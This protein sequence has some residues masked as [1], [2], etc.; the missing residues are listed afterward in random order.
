VYSVTAVAT[1][2]AADSAPSNAIGIT[3]PADLP[4]FKAGDTMKALA[5]VPVKS[6]TNLAGVPIST[7]A[8]GSTF[9]IVSGPLMNG[10]DAYW[11]ISKGCVLETSIRQ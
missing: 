9:V 5:I 8:N 7:I 2:P 4:K 1:P 10:T 6:C 3:L 11:K